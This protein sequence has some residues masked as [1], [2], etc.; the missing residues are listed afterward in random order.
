MNL[1]EFKISL[2][3]KQA[4]FF[5]F[6]QFLGFL[7]LLRIQ[8]QP[9][10]KEIVENETRGVSVWGFLVQFI[11]VTAVFLVLLPLFKKKPVFLKILFYFSIFIGISFLFELFLGEP[12]A[13]IISIGL[14]VLLIIKPFVIFHNLI[15]SAAFSSVGLILGITFQPF[16]VALILAILSL[17]DFIAVYFTRHMVKIAQVPA[18]EGIFFGLLIPQKNKFF[19]QTKNL[20]KI[21]SGT[22]FSF[23]GGGDMVFPLILSLSIA[24][25]S[26]L[27]GIIVSLF[28]LFGLFALHL[29]FHLR[30]DT[31]PMPG[32]PPLVFMTLLGYL[33]VTIF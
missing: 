5:I 23:L 4:F 15:F 11:V 8:N 2:F 22:D 30:T 12:L 26:F 6:T 31:K 19:S 7:A 14:I 9:I 17:Y 16:S 28:S 33:V 13:A 18:S 1:K 20:N 3:L 29:M 27:D 10:I 25:S 24:R 21:G 32:L